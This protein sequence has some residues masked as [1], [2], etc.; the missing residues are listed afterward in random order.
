MA[1]GST[2]QQTATLQPGETTTIDTDF[3]MHEGMGGPHLFDVTVKT[4]DPN[5]LAK[6]LEIASD[7]VPPS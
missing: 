1:V 7:W 6:H 2:A 4:N 3:M 5:A